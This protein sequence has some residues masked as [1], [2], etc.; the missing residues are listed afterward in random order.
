MYCQPSDIY[1]D[2]GEVNE[3][4][5]VDIKDDNEHNDNDDDGGDSNITGVDV[6]EPQNEVKMAVAVAT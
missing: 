5:K 1:K 6:E 2:E 4:D 3:T